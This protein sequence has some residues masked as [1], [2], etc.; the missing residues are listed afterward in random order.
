[1]S[2]TVF[3]FALFCLVAV[4]GDAL[5]APRLDKWAATNVGLAALKARYPK[6]YRDLILKYR[7]YVAKFDDG[8]WYVSGKNPFGGLGIKGGGVPIIEIR[9][10]DQKVLKIYFAR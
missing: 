4:T 9:D 6:E 2:Q 7:P 10:R 1:M 3:S 8:I 5:A